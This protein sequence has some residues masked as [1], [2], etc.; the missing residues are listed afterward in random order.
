MSLRWKNAVEGPWHEI[1]EQEVERA[2]KD[3][4][5]G[6]AA[7]LS[8]LTSDMLNYVGRKGVM[9]LLKVFQKIMRSGTMT[10]EWGD[11]LT[12]PL[13][14][15]KGDALHCGKYRGLRLQEHSIK[16]WA[17]VF[18]ERLNHVTAVDENQFG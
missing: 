17:R 6:R 12:V 15:G 8:G 3:M 14:K 4:K 13:Y 10:M 9:E 16:S 2:L 1:T 5:S 18:H 11:T 7:G